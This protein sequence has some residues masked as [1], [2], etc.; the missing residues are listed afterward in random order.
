MRPKK[1]AF[2][3]KYRCEEISCIVISVAS[4]PFICLS[5]FIFSQREYTNLAAVPTILCRSYY[6][7]RVM[8]A[9]CLIK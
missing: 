1:G 4:T 6:L 9:D 3:G 8:L 7:R 5:S 2:V